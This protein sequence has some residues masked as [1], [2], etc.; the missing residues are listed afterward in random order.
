MSYAFHRFLRRI[1]DPRWIPHIS[2]YCDGRCNR[3]TFT[4]RCWSYAQRRHEEKLTESGVSPADEDDEDDEDG[5]DESSED[6]EEG[7]EEDG[8][9]S[10]ALRP[11][12]WAERHGIDLNDVQMDAA[13]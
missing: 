8:N 12:G 11:L 6:H 9:Q 7:Q 1:R 2:S 3:C 13:D 5:E 10:E 4:E